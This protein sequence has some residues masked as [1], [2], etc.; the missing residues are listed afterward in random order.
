MERNRYLTGN[1]LE[2]LEEKMVFVGGA[3]QVGKTTLALKII[4]QKLTRYTYYNW[5]FPPDRKKLMSFEFPGD[6]ALLIF[7]EIHKYKRWKSLIKGI[8]D[9]YKSKYK[10]IVT[11]SAHL[12]IYK[13]GG[14]SLQGRYHYYT[15]HPFSLAELF[16]IKNNYTPFS[17]LNFHNENPKGFND[18]FH[19]L[20]KF[21]GFPEILFKQSE[22][23]LRRWHNEKLERLFREDIRDIEAIR[24]IGNMKLLGDLLPSKVASPLSINALREDLEVSHRA[25]TKW[26]YVLELFYYHFRI[27]PFHSRI[28]RSIK[29]EPKIYLIDWSE[30]QNDSARFENLIASHLLKFVQYINEYEGYKTTLNYLRNVDKKEVDFLVSSDSKPWFAVEVKLNDTQ[31]SPNISYFKER[32]KIPYLYQVVMKKDTDFIKDDIRVISADK[33]LT[34]LV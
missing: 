18:G 17:E 7:D 24:D 9:S 23:S 21:G 11:G 29:K 15:L 14:D 12:N 5:D 34:A 10:V 19:Q 1:V 16:S 4:T 28:I 31:P 33:F 20:F 26:L 32:L 30:V 13:K 2:D 25:A 6:E 27:Y 8:Y 3:R 22:Q